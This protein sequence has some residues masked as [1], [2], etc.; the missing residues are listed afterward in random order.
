M[1]SELFGAATNDF[2]SGRRLLFL[3]SQRFRVLGCEMFPVQTTVRLIQR[4]EKWAGLA[5]GMLVGTRRDLRQR[6]GSITRKRQLDQ[7]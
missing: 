1:A 2:D 5:A 3:Y 7:V 6:L 4:T